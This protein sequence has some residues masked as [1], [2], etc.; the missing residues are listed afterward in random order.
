MLEKEIS[1]RKKVK[2]YGFWQMHG[3]WTITNLQKQLKKIYSNI[4]IPIVLDFTFILYTS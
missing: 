1:I 4:K 2:S 3:N